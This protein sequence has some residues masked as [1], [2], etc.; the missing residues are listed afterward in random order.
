MEVE[1]VRKLSCSIP[2]VVHFRRFYDELN[3]VQSFSAKGCPNAV[4]KSFFKFLNTEEINSKTYS[5]LADLKIAGILPS[6][7]PKMTLTE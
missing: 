5:N 1:I 7:F 2:S 4:V 3:V 6:S